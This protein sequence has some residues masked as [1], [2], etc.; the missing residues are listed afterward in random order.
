MSL[1]KIKIVVL[2]AFVICISASSVSA[3]TAIKN[4]CSVKG[5]EENT[6]RGLG[7]VVGLSG[8]G[9]AGDIPT[10]RALARSYEL[11]GSPLGQTGAL[12]DLKSL[13]DLEKNKNIALVMVTATVP[14]AG[15]RRGT[16][17]ECSVS[18]LSGKS[19]A[20]G[21][22]AFAAL[23]GPNTKDRRVYALAQGQ[24]NIPNIAFPLSGKIH[25][26]CQ[27]EEDIFNPFEKDGVITLVIDQFP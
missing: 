25:K 1:T 9:E 13:K 23:Q 4:I 18:G 10:M 12:V 8:T 19:L 11:M 2:S 14:S 26:G 27:L 24:I 3:Q 6:L 17:L 15:G 5:Q 20:G 7:L 22:L 21:Y 16:K